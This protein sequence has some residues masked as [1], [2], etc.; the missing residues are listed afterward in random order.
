M[1]QLPLVCPQLGTWPATQAC[2]LP[3]NQAF[4]SVG[5][6]SAHCA[7]PARVRTTFYR[8]VF[9]VEG[10]FNQELKHS[11]PHSLT[12]SGELS[13]WV[14]PYSCL[15]DKRAVW[16]AKIFLH[17]LMAHR[18]NW[19]Y[20]IESE[21]RKCKV[22]LASFEEQQLQLT[23]ASRYREVSNWPEWFWGFEILSGSMSTSV[24]RSGKFWVISTYLWTQM[25]M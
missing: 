21:Y 2:A 1:D 14:F 11:R 5:Q 9:V 10:R 24:V 7:T 17:I 12:E 20:L 25:S 6:H 8:E 3:G 23:V 22:K 15:N 18:Q 16:F 19:K 4:W 13:S